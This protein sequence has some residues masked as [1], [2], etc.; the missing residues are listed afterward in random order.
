MIYSCRLYSQIEVSLQISKTKCKPVYIDACKYIRTCTTRVRAA[1]QFSKLKCKKY[2]ESLSI[3]NFVQFDN[4]QPSLFDTQPVLF[5]STNEGKC[6]VFQILQNRKTHKGKW[7]MEEC[8]I[9]MKHSNIFSKNS[10]LH[11]FLRVHLERDKDSTKGRKCK[12]EKLLINARRTYCQQFRNIGSSYCR[13]SE[14]DQMTWTWSFNYVASLAIFLGMNSPISSSSFAANI[15]MRDLGMKSWLE[16]RVEHETVADVQAFSFF[17][18]LNQGLRLSTRRRKLDKMT[19]TNEADLLVLMKIRVEGSYTHAEAALRGL[20]TKT[21]S[22]KARSMSLTLVFGQKIFV[23]KMLSFKFFAWSGKIKSMHL[24]L[25]RN[26]HTTNFVNMGVFFVPK[27]FQTLAVYSENEDFNR[28]EKIQNYTIV[29]QNVFL[30]KKKK[31]T[32]FRTENVL[33]WFHASH[34]C[35]LKGGHLPVF[36]TKDDEFQFIAV[37]QS[38]HNLEFIEAVYLGLKSMFVNSKVS[39]LSINIMIACILFP[40]VADILVVLGVSQVGDKCHCLIPKLEKQK[41]WKKRHKLQ[42]CRKFLAAVLPK[43]Q[44]AKAQ[45]IAEGNSEGKNKVSQSS[46]Q[47]WIF[48]CITHVDQSSPTRVVQHTLSHTI[49]CQ[50]F[51]PVL[52]AA[53]FFSTFSCRQH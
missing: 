24:N 6:V 52:S 20:I 36:L 50:Y 13:Q 45:S 38:A 48:L 17:S 7:Y 51:L 37:M 47:K 43:S 15:L 2:L 21:I 1:D 31:Y 44:R 3:P 39:T 40:F 46:F 32:M 29:Q 4:L 16:W 11:Y 30:L 18:F 9:K 27:L 10:Y 33:T 41:I 28:S 19:E 35:K 8:A 49:L 53:K 26:L 25:L 5:F 14:G 12:E 22:T 23:S 42:A 34:L